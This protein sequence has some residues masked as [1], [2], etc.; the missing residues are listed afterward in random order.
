MIAA[1]LAVVCMIGACSSPFALPTSGDVRTLQPVLRQSKRVY[2]T[3][4]GPETDAQPEAIVTGFLDA[5]PAGVQDDGYR[6]ARE[7]LTDE[8][9]ES[10]NGDKSAIIYDGAV[11]TRRKTNSTG[12]SDTQSD[13]SVIVVVSVNATGRLDKQGLFSAAGAGDATVDYRLVRQDGQW[14]ISELPDGVIISESDFEQVYR[15]VSVY[16]TDRTRAVLIPDV[17]WFSWR[18]W[19]TLAVRESLASP[20]DWLAG[21][22]VDLN[23]ADVRLAVNTVPMTD[24]DMHV[25]LTDDIAAMND[26][27]RALLVHLI[28]LT[29][30]DGTAS[31]AVK[32]TSDNG[33]YSAA[34]NGMMLAA[35]LPVTGMYTLSGGNV[36]SLRSASPLRVAQTGGFDGALG[37]VYADGGGA[38]LRADHAVECLAD[39][40]SSCGLLF[41]GRRMRAIVKGVDGEIWAIG[42]DGRSLFVSRDGVTSRV[43]VPW[44]DDGTAMTAIAVSPEGS[45]LAVSLKA[46]NS[47]GDDAAVGNADGGASGGGTNGGDA[48][49]GSAAGGDVDGGG[50]VDGDDAGTGGTRSAGVAVSGV[51]RGDDGLPDALSDGYAFAAAQTGVTMLTFYND[52][53]LVYG[54]DADDDGVQP[55]FRQITPGPAEDQ[56][57]P[58]NTVALASG[59]IS[60]YR[61]LV[62]LDAKGMVR[63]ASGSLDG[64][65]AFADSQVAALSAQ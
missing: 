44:L 58:E 18:N 31:D 11:S 32:V 22:A 8:A 21:A 34:D 24:G 52:V 53:M 20:P 40:G 15:Q 14:R 5:L 46:A 50:S 62:A 57:L 54:E 4:D 37:F 47:G 60:S 55:A 28:R 64:A 3:P 7:F 41:S 10:W 16:R 26:D 19:R 51:V 9:A 39:D 43:A 29:L 63:S 45:R 6:V 35:S 59:M 38:V 27:D 17:R 1:V 2:T 13:G 33:D 49:G 42:E 25:Q 56:Q 12:T 61:R 30:G 36:V 48:D 65:W 23:T